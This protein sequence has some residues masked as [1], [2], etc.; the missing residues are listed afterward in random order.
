MAF[1]PDL[2]LCKA[3][4]SFAKLLGKFLFFSLSTKRNGP[5]VPRRPERWMSFTGDIHPEGKVDVAFGYRLKRV[6]VSAMAYWLS[7]GHV[8]DDVT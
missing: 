6:N 4:R 7:S 5:T 8:A 2:K 3:S 1:T